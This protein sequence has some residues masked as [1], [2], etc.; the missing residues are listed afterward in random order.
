MSS[1]YYIPAQNGVSS[2]NNDDL[3][4]F[5]HLR[6]IP[7]VPDTDPYIDD[8]NFGECQY[9][10]PIGQTVPQNLFNI[11]WLPHYNQLYNPDTKTMEVKVNLQPS[12]IATFKFSDYVMIRNRAYRVNRIDY[13]PKDLSTVEFILIV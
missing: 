11:Y 7:T 9:F 2:E 3:F 1:S 5:S 10:Q 12:D 8:F 13:K 4:T 6:N